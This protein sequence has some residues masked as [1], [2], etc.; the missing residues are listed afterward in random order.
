MVTVALWV[1]LYMFVF[2]GPR[3][4]FPS[5]M[6]EYRDHLVQALMT[7]G[8]TERIVAA[9]LSTMFIMSV[10]DQ[11]YLKDALSGINAADDWPALALIME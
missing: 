5:F 9:L 7:F 2:G 4:D 3:K 10:V 11:T 6:K 8:N 1:V